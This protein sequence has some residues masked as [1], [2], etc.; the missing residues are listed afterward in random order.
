MQSHSIGPPMRMWHRDR[1]EFHAGLLA[2]WLAYFDEVN[3]SVFDWWYFDAVSVSDPR[4]SL[5]VIFF[6][7]TAAA[8]PWLP[9]N[10]SSVLIAYLWV[11]FAN[12]TIFEEYVPATIAT[13]AGGEDASSPS[14][15]NWSS[16]GLSWAASQDDLSQYEVIISSK[17]MQAK[18]DLV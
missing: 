10:E 8:F 7:T 17:Q 3:P 5:M 18:G 11:S 2:T 14:S 12:G 15:G 1:S 9:S 6:T 16:T 4:E 13:V